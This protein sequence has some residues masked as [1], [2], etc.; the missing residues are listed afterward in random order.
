MDVDDPETQDETP[1]Q[2]SRST[3]TL[4][5][6]TDNVALVRDLLARLGDPGVAE[7]VQ[8]LLSRRTLEQSPSGKAQRT[9]NNES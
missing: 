8:Q 5:S 3:S 4:T 2:S 7:A 9:E 6:A 1:T